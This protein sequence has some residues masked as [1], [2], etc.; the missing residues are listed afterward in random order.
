MGIDDA[1]ALE[2]AELQRLEATERIGDKVREHELALKD[3][4][5]RMARV[6]WSA[7]GHDRFVTV[8]FTSVPWTIAWIMW[9]V[10]S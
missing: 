7:C 8:L 4:E 6:N 3:R 1:L 2:V 9:K 5:I 10:M